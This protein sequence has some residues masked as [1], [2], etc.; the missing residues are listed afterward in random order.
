M[1][2]YIVKFEY[3]DEFELQDK[4]ETTLLIFKNCWSL[5]K[6]SH[7]WE[8]AKLS[9]AN[10]KSLTKQFF[11]F[12]TICFLCMFDS[13]IKGKKWMEFTICKII[14]EINNNKT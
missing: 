8:I 5:E 11:L 14:I 2:S 13:I 10:V 9:Y 4:Y 1:Y 3:L 7:L 12:S 6:I